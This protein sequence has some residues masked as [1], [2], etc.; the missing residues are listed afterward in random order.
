MNLKQIGAGS[1]V[2]FS[3][4]ILQ[5]DLWRRKKRRR[6]DNSCTFAPSGNKKDPYVVQDYNEIVEY[7]KLECENADRSYRDL[8]SKEI[9][10]DVFF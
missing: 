1:S 2:C 10:I 3:C 6:T 7:V 5:D 9:G 4:P 8:F